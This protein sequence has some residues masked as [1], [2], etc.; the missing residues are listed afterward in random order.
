[1]GKRGKVSDDAPPFEE[2]TIHVLEGMM[3]HL[4]E[5][6]NN[7]VKWIEDTITDCIRLMLDAE[8]RECQ[9][10]NVYFKHGHLVF[11]FPKQFQ[12]NGEYDNS[13]L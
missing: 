12:L 5:V 9:R 1:M 7:P 10:A 13:P 6:T 4:R 3:D 11:R 8:V 2:L